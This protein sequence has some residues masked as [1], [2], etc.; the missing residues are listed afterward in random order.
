MFEYFWKQYEDLPPDLGYMRFSA[1]HIITLIVLFVL[2]F[3]AVRILTCKSSRLA[4]AMQVMPWI[5]VCMEVFKDAFLI[6][7]GHFG[8]G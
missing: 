7:G 4:A 2:I 8:P 6:K 3:L 1:E 5:M